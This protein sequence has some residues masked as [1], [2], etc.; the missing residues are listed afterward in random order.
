MNEYR[1]DS[2]LKEEEF[3]EDFFD[4]A[5]AASK[6]LAEEWK[7]NI[8]CNDSVSK[9]QQY[10]LSTDE[11]N[12]LIFDSAF[13]FHDTKGFSSV[14]IILKSS[15]R[16]VNIRIKRDKNKLIGEKLIDKRLKKS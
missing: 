13:V 12:T 11:S 4:A 1:K 8:H 5:I 15:N 6:L 2:Y 9:S 10:F 16:I 3:L 14:Q 7:P